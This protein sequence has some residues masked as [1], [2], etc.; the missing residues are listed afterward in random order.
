MKNIQNLIDLLEAKKENAKELKKLHIQRR[1][2][3]GYNI[4]DGKVDAFSFCIKELNLL[5]KENT[6]AI[7]ES[8][9]FANTMLGEVPLQADSS[10]TG[11]VRQNEQTGKPCNCMQSS[12]QRYCDN[13]CFEAEEFD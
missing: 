4:N 2:F 6:G 7:T 3:R 8:A 10:E 9:H 13:T 5:L 11:S 12:L 1:N